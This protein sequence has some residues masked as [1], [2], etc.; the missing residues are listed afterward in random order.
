M[1][2]I[3]VLNYNDYETTITFVEQIK[4]YSCLQHICIV[5]NAST[6]GSIEKLQLYQSHKL[7]IICSKS[8]QGYSSGNNLGAKYLIEERKCDYIFISN[9]DIEVTEKAMEEMI[10]TIQENNQVALLGPTI[11]EN[12]EINRGWKLPSTTNDILSN[13]PSIYKIARKKLLYKEDKY[14]TALTKV[15]VVSGCFFLIKSSILKEFNYFDEN[16]FLYYEENILG[17][18]L[19]ANNY[20]SFVLNNIRVIHHHSVSIDKSFNHLHK[21][22]IL[23]ESQRYYQKNYNNASF[24]GII[25]LYITYYIYMVLSYITIALKQV[26]K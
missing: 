17:M 9:P 21:I 4:D 16:T 2:G 14:D 11:Y 18:K 20:S 1:I 8:N 26:V 24:I 15:D 23:K 22:K 7:H 19:K 10:K 3:V 25:G 6:D 5:D 12:G 13:L